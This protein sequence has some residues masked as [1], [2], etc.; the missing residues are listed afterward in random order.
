MNYG[1]VQAQVMQGMNISGLIKEIAKEMD[2]D[3]DAIFP[4]PGVEE[5]EDAIDLELNLI[6]LGV[7]PD[8]DPNQDSMKALERYMEFMQTDSFKNASEN[9]HRIM[10]KFIYLSTKNVTNSIKQKIDAIRR[11]NLETR[12]GQN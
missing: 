9:V 6:M 8:L 7:V 10:Q 12:T 1:K 4:V 11:S 3:L 5:G 2:L